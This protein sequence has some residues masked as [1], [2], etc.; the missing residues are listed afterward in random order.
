ML[1]AAG[2]AAATGGIRFSFNPSPGTAIAKTALMTL[3]VFVMAGAAEE[4]L[5]RG[6]P[7]QTFTARET[8]MGRRGG[9]VRGFWRGAPRESECQQRPA[10]RQHRYRRSL[11]RGRVHTHAKHVVTGG[12]ALVMELDPSRAPRYSRKRQRT[13]CIGSGTARHQCRT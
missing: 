4:A 9:N 7:L 1:L 2:I 8:R 10:F 12:V 13:I 11:V 3:V 6:Y 5:F